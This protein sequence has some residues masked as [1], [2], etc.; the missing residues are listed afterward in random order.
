MDETKHKSQIANRKSHQ[1]PSR[2]DVRARRVW[3]N[4]QEL[5]LTRLEYELLAYLAKQNGKVV[6]YQ[7]LW[8][9][10]WQS[11]CRVG[12]TEI[13]TMREAAK[14]LRSKLCDSSEVCP[15]ENVR[16]IGFRLTQRAMAFDSD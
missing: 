5:H 14:R 9:R 10:V 12:A 3:N 7:E 16:G 8:R 1:S 6:T 2:M 15:L 11:D 13:I 4:G